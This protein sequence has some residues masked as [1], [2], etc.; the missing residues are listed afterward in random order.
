[1]KKYYLVFDV[2]GT[3]LEGALASSVG[4]LSYYQSRPSQNHL[5]KRRVAKNVCT[6]VEQV[7]AAAQGNISA[8]VLGWPSR[9]NMCL[10]GPEIKKV[11]EKKFRRPVV[12]DNDANL[13]A[14]GEAVGG[15]GK[16]YRYVVGLT[17]G[18]GI[19][20]GLVIDKKLYYGQGGASEFGHVTIDYRGPR[21]SCGSRGCWE[22]YAG[23]KGLRRLAKKYKLARS[24][25]DALYQLALAGNKKARRLWQDFGFYLGIGLASLINAY[26]PD[27]IIL[28]G[29]I[30]R[31][32]NF[33]RLSMERIIKQRVLLKPCPVRPSRLPNAALVG[34]AVLARQ[35]K[36]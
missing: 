22:E 23:K 28:G 33:F 14:L 24:D 12:L 35:N 11:L 31:A 25:G 8:M 27:V 19:G 4:S 34:A 15:Q 2:G 10:S 17:M 20:C 21:C 9:A 32:Y 5:G 7:G 6:L 13:F 3:N 1:M 30:S 29:K 26:H 18:T 36:F 16:K